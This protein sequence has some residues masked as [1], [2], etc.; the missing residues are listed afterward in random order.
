MSDWT[1]KLEQMIAN[2][3]ADKAAKAEANS[4]AESDA[5]ACFANAIKPGLEEFAT[6][7]R[8]RG[9][10]VMVQTGSTYAHI[11]VIHNDVIEVEINYSVEKGQIS[12]KPQRVD[13]KTGKGFQTLLGL[14]A[15]AD[16]QAVIDQILQQYQ[17]A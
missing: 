3:D 2:R 6:E 7:L 14:V 11:R 9:R 17:P 15:S 12:V 16:K 1:T 8:N 5:E 4:K 13:R 10:T